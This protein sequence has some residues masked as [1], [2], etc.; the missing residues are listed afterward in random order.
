MA[1]AAVRAHS[2]A[3]AEVIDRIGDDARDRLS[4]L[5]RE[6]LLRQERTTE[7]AAPVA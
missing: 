2:R 1:E 5:L 7:P 4:E 6:L 3:T